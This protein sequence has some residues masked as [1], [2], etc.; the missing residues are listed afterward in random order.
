[1]GARRDTGQWARTVSVNLNPTNVRI[2]CK[3]MSRF[4]RCPATGLADSSAPA[5][6]YQAPRPPSCLHDGRAPWTKGSRRERTERVPTAATVASRAQRRLVIACG[7]MS[8]LPAFKTWPVRWCIRSNRSCRGACLRGSLIILS[9]LSGIAS[10]W[11]ALWCSIMGTSTTSS[12][13]R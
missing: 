4:P 12:L 2:R 3:H 8:S 1:M 13:S 5:D 7:I 9:L 10:S 6:N 11:C